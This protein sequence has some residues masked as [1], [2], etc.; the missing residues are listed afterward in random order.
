LKKKFLSIFIALVLALSLCLVTA[1][2]VAAAKPADKGFD[3][4]G[5]NYQ[6]RIFVGIG[7]DWYRGK[8]GSDLG[9]WQE[10]QD[11]IWDETYGRDHLGFKWSKAWVDATFGPD[12]VRDNGDESDWTPQA[13][14]TNEWNGMAPGGSGEVWHYTNIWVGPGG[15]SSQYWRDGGYSIWG[16]FEVIMSHGVVDGEHI[17]DTLATPCGRGGP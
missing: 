3:E 5:Y 1:V 12:G 14:C 10:G 13:W 6:A 16:N 7:E 4:Y 11:F 2:P 9:P 17:W 8:I 15:E